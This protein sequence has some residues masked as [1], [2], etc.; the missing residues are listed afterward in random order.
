MISTFDKLRQLRIAYETEL[1]QRKEEYSQAINDAKDDYNR[2]LSIDFVD[3]ETM[4][5]E[6]SLESLEELYQDIVDIYARTKGLTFSVTRYMS[7]INA[8]PVPH[9][10]VNEYFD[11]LV[12]E[13]NDA[14]D[15]IE[16]NRSPEQD[17]VPIKAFCQGLADLRYVVKNA[18]RLVEETGDTQ[19]RKQELLQR[20][21]ERI[22]E[23]E[24]EYKEQTKVENFDC[25]ADLDAFS[26]KVIGEYQITSDSML[27][28]KPIKCRNDHKFLM[29][30]YTADVPTVDLNFAERI[31]NIPSAAFATNPIYFNLNADHST[32]LIN[33]PKEFYEKSHVFFHDERRKLEFH[34]L[35]T[36]IYLSFISNMPA[37]QFLF[38]G[39]EPDGAGDSVLGGIEMS[40]NEKLETGIYK[41]VRKKVDT[42]TDSIPELFEEIKSLCDE[43]SAIYTN[44]GIS[45][46]FAY[47][48]KN[49]S[50]SNFFLMFVANRYPYG[51]DTTHYDGRQELLKMATRNGSKGVISVICQESDAKF[52]ANAQ[53]FTAEELNADV[54]DISPDGV[55]TYNGKRATLDIRS[56]EFDYDKYMSELSNYLV[57]ASSIWLYDILD[58][59]DRKP[60]SVKHADKTGANA[61]YKRISVPMGESAGK[62]FD[63]SMKACSTESFALLVGAAESGK[64]SFLHTFI[65][66]AAAKYSPDELQLGLI[67]FK[68]KKDSPEFSQYVKRPDKENLYIPHVKYLMVNG[69]EECAI[70]LFNMIVDIKNERSSLFTQAGVTELSAYN[71]SEMVKSGKLPRLPIYLFIIDEYNV[72]LEGDGKRDR[73]VNSMIITALTTTIQAV[74]AYGI[75]IM[76]SG[77]SVAS[78]LT[79]ETGALA[80]MKTRISLYT[81]SIEGYGTLMGGSN[82][83]GRDAKNEVGYLRDKGFS[84]FTS[85]AGRTRTQ[86]RHAY[87]GQTGCKRQ[88]ELAKRIRQ[89][90]GESDQLVAGDVTKFSVFN[91]TKNVYTV[92]KVEKKK[93]QIPLGV[94]SASMKAQGLE[95]SSEQDALN[96]FAFASSEQIVSIEQNAIFSFLSTARRQNIPINKV[97]YLTTF[98]SYNGYF[99]GYFDA[100]PQL[101]KYVDLVLGEEVAA[102]KF[103]EIYDAFE[104][105]RARAAK[106]RCEFDPLFVVMHDIEWLTDDNVSWL[107]AINE[108]EPSAGQENG[109]VV[110]YSG[111]NVT[112]EDLQKNEQLAAALPPALMAALAKKVQSGGEFVRKMDKP[113]TKSARRRLSMEDVRTMFRTLYTRGNRYRIFLLVTSSTME[114]INK[115]IIDKLDSTGKVNAKESYAVYGSQKERDGNGKRDKDSNKDCIYVCP[116]ESNTRLF[117]FS[118]QVNAKWWDEFM[119]I[120]K[121]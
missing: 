118:P 80:Q 1:K 65:L 68:A 94:S 61:F 57:K 99:D 113:Q 25:Y 105:R 27:S 76:L 56:P 106:E 104:A 11:R 36:N 121:D 53:P 84:I 90:W 88:L 93:F 92:G 59:E 91:D 46:I 62:Q 67:D 38:T 4:R 19:R 9:G 37:K 70:D 75:G 103:I 12:E 72:M 48:E 42:S 31:L 16:R 83:A 107:D 24:K 5:F 108:Q 55:I 33:A 43:R 40:I 2:S 63:F 28:N 6:V 17:V 64:S 15:A 114:T 115:A 18:R 30:F 39:V 34:K 60:A 23:A 32:L 85:D 102:K 97:Q 120:L 10:G 21:K 79:G 109:E 45:D 87:A 35:L 74:R 14:L 41:K 26:K 119:K 116:E 78:G 54:I 58:K 98:E 101:N 100:Y 111:V 69:K 49:P 89:Q 73:K 82:V 77:Q 51:F 86:V 47:N 13:C 22:S 50:S 3:E 110:K 44:R 52:T 29:G 8:R 112:V 117:D 20:K 66:S 96:Y 81:N 7:S 95:Y 71:E